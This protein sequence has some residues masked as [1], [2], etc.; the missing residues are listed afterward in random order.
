ML[1]IG[2][3][4]PMLPANGITQSSF[5]TSSSSLAPSH[6]SHE[7]RRLVVMVMVMLVVVVVVVMVVVIALIEVLTVVVV[8]AASPDDNVPHVYKCI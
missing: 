2:V 1:S 7:W 3:V 5:R 4:G 8:A 6:T